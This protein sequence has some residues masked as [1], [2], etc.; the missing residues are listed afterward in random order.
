MKRPRITIPSDEYD[1][2]R[3]GLTLTQHRLAEAKEEL[4]AARAEGSSLQD[5][6]SRLQEKVRARAPGGRPKDWAEGQADLLAQDKVT[7][8]REVKHWRD[9]AL[10]SEDDY[11]RAASALRAIRGLVPDMGMALR[12]QVAL[13]L[14]EN[15]G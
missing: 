10:V 13:A 1:A 4:A 8:E 5:R 14:G 7:L 15:Y 6:V 12:E 2:L 3:A 11:R 9:R